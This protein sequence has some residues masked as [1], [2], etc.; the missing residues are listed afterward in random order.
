[1]DFVGSS[2]A[3]NHVYRR[4]DHA[5]EVVNNLPGRVYY[6]FDGS[7]ERSILVWQEEV[8]DDVHGVEIRRRLMKGSE[9]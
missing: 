5:G 8:V 4:P 2:C 7:P 3:R 1:M 9:Q 6:L